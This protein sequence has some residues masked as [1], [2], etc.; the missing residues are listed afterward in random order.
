MG[1]D[2]QT[3][4]PL[5]KFCPFYLALTKNEENINDQHH[6]EKWL[7]YGIYYNNFSRTSLDFGQEKDAMW[8]DYTYYQTDKGPI[9]YYMI[10]GGESVQKVT[11]SFGT[12]M[13]GYTLMPKSMFGYLASSMGYAESE[14]AQE[15][16][17]QFIIKCRQT[18]Q[19]PCDGMHLSSGYTV[20]PKNENKAGGGDRWV[21][22]WNH[23]R[24]PDP[25][26][27]AK[28]Y[29]DA[30]MRIFANVKPWLLETHPD[31]TLMKSK[32]GFVWQALSQQQ[33]QQHNDGLKDQG[34]PGTIWQWRAGANTKGKASYID[35]TSHQGYDYWQQHLKTALLD[36]GYD[37]WLDNNEFTMTD[38]TQTY[39]RE[40]Q[41]NVYPS[42][43]MMPSY[44]SANQPGHVD[45]PIQT[46]LMIQSSYEVVQSYHPKK[47]PC[48][49]TRS[50]VPFCQ[51]LV[52]QTWS[53]DNFTEWKT[54][55]YNIPMGTGANLSA[56]PA[57]YGHD[58]GGFAGNAPSEEQL[59]RWIQQ[60][61][62]WTRFCIHS[63]NSDQTITEPWMY[64]NV[65]PIIRSS[66]EWRY[67]WI[68]NLYSLYITLTYRNNEPVIRPTFYDHPH[69]SQT[70][71]QDFEFMIGSQFL[72]APVYEQ[73][74]KYRQVY[75]PKF[76]NNT[77]KKEKNDG[78]Y[79]YQTGQYYESGNSILVPAPLTDAVSPLF[80]KEGS[81]MC[82]GKLM[83]YVN[84]SSDN[85][86]YIHIYPPP[87]PPPPSSSSS[88]SSSSPSSSSTPIRY[89]C[90]FIEDDGESVLHEQENQY[91]EIELW[92]EC[93]RDQIKVGITILHD[94]YIPD[95]DTLWVTCPLS[96]EKRS[97]V[98]DQEYNNN[99][100]QPL[101]QSKKVDND[102]LY[103]YQGLNLNF[104]KK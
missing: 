56:Q 22:T 82:F 45:T 49:I 61:I 83:Q 18:Y 32:H 27:L 12:L 63:Y 80:I 86:R 75:L 5:Y 60:G 21:F 69:D 39:L 93:D 71:Q 85:E 98:F 59:V 26:G 44:Y 104:L 62:F 58:V 37:I 57:G 76:N 46:L 84:A 11:Q 15:Q 31:Y 24:F 87:P 28:K 4:D 91:T 103:K 90:I 68:P 38:D 74:K 53:G 67:K 72:V 78:W 99:N 29:H 40:K 43:S 102:Q 6:Q 95:Y 19:I 33:Q 54:L 25:I 96:S 77:S 100:T 81:F 65:L 9:D 94:G 92:M 64:P 20:Q 8:G 7:A 1:Y 23:Q 42:F 88:S 30:G 35:F 10:Y 13:G 97:I 70:H 34:Q 36:Y 3:Q 17:E 101:Y 79:H 55:A 41:C 52:S 89:T 16:L 50:T 2:A 14:N 73:G 51:S 47:R 48:L 66:I